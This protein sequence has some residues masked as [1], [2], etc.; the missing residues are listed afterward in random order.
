[1]LP[2]EID[3]ATARV[4]AW[5]RAEVLRRIE[6]PKRE[7]AAPAAGTSPQCIGRVPQRPKPEVPPCACGRKGYAKGK[8]RKCYHLVYDRARHERMRRKGQAK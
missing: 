2:S 6:R 4:H 7:K 8:C 1:M 5:L 3:A